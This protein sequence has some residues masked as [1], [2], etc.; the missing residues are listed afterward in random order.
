[1]SSILVR[2]DLSPSGRAALQWA[3]E[4]A[5][6]TARNLVAINAAHIPPSLA[7]IGVIAMPEPR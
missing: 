3:A 4:Q 1:M 2:L 7:S 5:R 6:L